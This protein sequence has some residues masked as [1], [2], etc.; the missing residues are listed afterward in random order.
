[1]NPKEIKMDIITIEIKNVLH[2]NYCIN[3]ADGEKIYNIIDKAFKEDKLVV[4]SFAD[5]ELIIAAFLNNAV[6][7]LYKHYDSNMVESHLSAK[8]MHEDFHHIWKK[9]IKD[10]PRYYVN[11]E[12]FDRHIT[13]LIEED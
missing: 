6:G 1:M 8:D 7:K 4:L 11:Q 5:I 13:D 3:V 2:T 10:S 12:K 9:V